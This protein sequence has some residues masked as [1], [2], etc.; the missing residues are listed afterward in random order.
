MSFMG[1]GSG[2]WKVGGGT[3]LLVVVEGRGEDPLHQRCQELLIIVL[4]ISQITH[5]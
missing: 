4:Y 1:G 3:D 2:R 5:R